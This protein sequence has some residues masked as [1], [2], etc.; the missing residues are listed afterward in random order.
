MDPAER[1]K[2]C[3][4]FMLRRRIGKIDLLVCARLRDHDDAVNLL[5]EWAV[6]RALPVQVAGNLCAK[7]GDRDEPPQDVLRD[8]VG[9]AGVLSAVAVDVHVLSAEVKIRSGNGSCAP[10][11]STGKLGRLIVACRCRDDFIAVDVRSAGRDGCELAL[12]PCLLF[13]LGNLLALDGRSLD[14]HA[15]DDVADFGLRQGRDV[16]I[17]ALPVLGKDQV[18]ELDLGFDPLVVSQCWPDVVRGS[19]GGALGPEDNLGALI[20]DMQ[21]AKNQ[22]QPRERGVAADRLEPVVE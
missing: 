2:P 20:V 22:N 12:F 4:H 18:L 21:C 15:E 8:N 1:L 17:V 9:V 7:I 16:D 3:Q 13:N 14:F 19:D 6:C 11:R 5:D 10:I